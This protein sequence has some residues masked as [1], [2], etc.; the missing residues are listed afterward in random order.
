MASS[1]IG[2]LRVTL[3]LDSASFEDGLDANAKRAAKSSK[4]F[5]AMGNKM[6]GVGKRMSLTM[7]LPLAGFAAN[8]AKVASDVEELNS[9]FDVSF[10]KMSGSVRKWAEE[11]GNAMGRSTQ[12]LQAQ[13]LAFQDIFKGVMGRGEAAEM[14]KEMTVLSQDLASMKNLSNDVALQKILSGLV[15][16]SEPLRSVGVLLSEAKIEARALA[17]GLGDAT[18]KL[19]EQDKV[20]ARAA[21]ITAQLGDAQGDLIRT[22]GS[23]ANQAKR[24]AAA[25]EELNVVV[26]TKLLPAIT[27]VIEKIADAID[28]FAKLPSGAQNAF[29]GVAAAGAVLGP[30]IGTIGALIAGIA[31]IAPAVLLMKA[32]LL[33]ALAVIGRT[34]MG[35]IA[36]TGPLGL[37]ILAVSAAV[38][39]WYNWDEIG[40][41][42]KR[43]YNTVKTWIH[44]KLGKIFDKVKGFITGVRDAFYDMADK[45]AFHSYVP[46][47]VDIVIEQF[48]RL[49]TGM[50]NPA[51]AA[52]DN[53]ASSFEDMADRASSAIQGLASSIKSG[54]LGGI[55]SGVLDIVS[56]GGSIF[57]SKKIDFGTVSANDLMGFKNGGS[58]NVGGRGGVDK[59]IV[60][61]RAT[62]GERVDIS[63][64]AQQRSGGGGG[65][66]RLYLDSDLLR[67]EVIGGAVQVV[68]AAAPDIMR[69]GA[70]MALRT[71]RRPT[72]GGGP[73]RGTG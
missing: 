18:G 39:I 41:I 28:W 72:L 67:A 15:G 53:V 62:K 36:S 50:V 1:L 16:E 48:G 31:K 54:N 49:K 47:M 46:D 66:V 24:M 59:N 68:Q 55:L 58:F 37:I 27:P 38:A 51:V 7:S 45:V 70:G 69:G 33:P 9:A 17:M 8:A 21:E 71:A 25:F 4:K 10:G 35:L 64:S 52:N 12:E 73:G 23:S 13:A 6:A 14:A 26:G 3:G 60:A 20:V 32:K 43:L 44:D 11:T 61:F 5:Q 2:A 22:G 42:V 65:E 30:I 56:L 19:S 57:G 34:I 63:T 29:L 40:P